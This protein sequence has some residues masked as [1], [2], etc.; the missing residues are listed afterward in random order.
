MLRYRADRRTFMRGDKLPAREEK[1]MKRINRLAPI[2]SITVLSACSSVQHASGAAQNLVNACAHQPMNAVAAQRR[3]RSGIVIVRTDTGSAGTGFIVKGPTGALRI[4]TNYHVITDG[5]QF[6]VELRDHNDRPIIL[7]RL[8]V[9]K[10]DPVHDLALL[11]MPALPASASALPLSPEGAQG[12][13]ALLILGYPAVK[14]SSPTLTVERG[15]VT[16]TRR[17]VQGG[18][19]IQ[20]NANVNPGNSGGPAVDSC[21]QVI[22]VV[23]AFMEG[24]ERTGLIIP[25]KMVRHLLSLEAKV[26]APK[27]AIRA[28]LDG[29]FGALATSNA[30]TAANYLS[31][32]FL[33]ERVGPV[34]QRALKA[35]VTKLPAFKAMVE[36]Q[37]YQMDSVPTPIFQRTFKKMFSPDEQVVFALAMSVSS[38]K[39]SVRAASRYFFAGVSETLLDR[40]HEHRVKAIYVQEQHARAVVRLETFKGSKQIIVSMVHE[41]GDWHLSGFQIN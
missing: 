20:T 5:S 9:E 22:G 41:W 19:Y 35:I 31:P 2:M 18:R 15:D 23:R 4:V 6:E 14:G 1:T 36:A 27:A 34:L 10:V 32:S 3:A 29:F 11:R 17:T 30:V 33:D 28:R 40:V 13:Q 38:G 37:G 25:A 21:G 24:T 39:L 8:E 26:L 16:S 7:G 12:G